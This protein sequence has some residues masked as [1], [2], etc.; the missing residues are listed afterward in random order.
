V[1]EIAHYL[2]CDDHDLYQEWLDGMRDMRA[3]VRIMARVERLRGGNYGDCKPLHDGVWE[4]R[5]DCGPGY[6]V[7]YAQAGSHMVLLLSGGDKRRQ[8]KDV[9]RA[10][11]SLSDYVSRNR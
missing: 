2:N 10:V 8:K 1:F 4:L 11:E 6:R 5:I 9:V 3:K 7:Y